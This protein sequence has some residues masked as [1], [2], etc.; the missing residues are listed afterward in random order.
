MK[1]SK[2]KLLLIGLLLFHSVSSSSRKLV[3]SSDPFYRAVYLGKLEKV[4][5]F[6]KE[7]VSQEKKNIALLSPSDE[8]TRKLLIKYGADVNATNHQGNTPLHLL[9]L[10]KKYI[11]SDL[12]SKSEKK[13]L[14]KEIFNY[15]WNGPPKLL[16]ENGADV[17]AKNYQGNTP[18]HLAIHKPKTA[19]FFI[20]NGADVNA[21]NY[22]GNT[23]L[24]LAI[25]KPKTAEFFIKNGADVNAKNYQGNTP[26][27][28]AIHEPKRIEFFIEKGADVNIQNENGE[29][30]LHKLISSY[31]EGRYNSIS[32]Y[33]SMS[34]KEKEILKVI[35]LLAKKGADINIQ[36]KNG[37]TALHKLISFYIKEKD[38]IWNTKKYFKMI[39]LLIENGADVNARN[40]KGETPLF[41]VEEP[42]FAKLLIKYG[43]DIKIKDKK[44]N[45]PLDYANFITKWKLRFYLWTNK[46]KALGKKYEEQ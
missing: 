32:S 26:L 28:L 3:V 7:G 36:N 44:G 10:P 20:E 12:S 43:A 39:Q 8:Y 25:H 18:L 2:I 14:E 19:E 23:P 45:T 16:I 41:Y 4:E 42:E 21:K 11:L 27:H 40:N 5:S 31:V 15:F 9:R 37:G 6:L 24:H 34:S 33:N 35:P 29:T 13:N 17:N 1:N 46:I 30:A 38:R 22:Q